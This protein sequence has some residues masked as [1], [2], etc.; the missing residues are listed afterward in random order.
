V[1]WSALIEGAL[2]SSPMALVLGFAV[3]T[4]WKSNAEKDAE[5]R[6]LNEKMVDAMLEIAHR[7]DQ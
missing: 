4:L 7:D 5:I 2:G 3:W 1:E 6:R